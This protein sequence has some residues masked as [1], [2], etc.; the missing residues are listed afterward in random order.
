MDKKH[1]R[2]DDLKK[3][4]PFTVPDGYFEN[5]PQLIQSR[6]PNEVVRK[7]LIQWTWQRAAGLVAAM[8][9]LLVMVWVTFPERQGSLGQ[10]PLSKISDASIVSYLEEQNISY[11]D[12]SEH[13][14]VQKAFDTD[15]TVLNYLDGLDD[16]FLRQQILETGSGSEKI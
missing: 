9:F 3:E 11:Y 8:S 6:I 1:I 16:D 10:E 12:L 14:V 13:Q 4:T 15:S 5:L 7:P 2:L